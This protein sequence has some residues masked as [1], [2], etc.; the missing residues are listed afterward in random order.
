MVYVPAKSVADVTADHETGG[1][2][3][4]NSDYTLQL[5]LLKNQKCSAW[6]LSDLF[7]NLFDSKKK[8]SWE[9]VKAIYT[10]NLGFWESVE[11]SA[12]E[13]AKLKTLYK[14]A[15]A[16]KSKDTK[17]MYKTINALGNA[18][19]ALLMSYSEAIDAVS[20]TIREVN[21]RAVA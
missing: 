16:R 17:T 14:D 8:P 11:I 5:D 21:L 15:C 6:I 1:L 19:I 2:A 4:G 20:L 12:E 10:E 3:L 9:E 13:E 7:V 18:G